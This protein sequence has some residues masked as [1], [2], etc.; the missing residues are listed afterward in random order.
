MRPDWSGCSKLILM[1]SKPLGK[2][3]ELISGE[4]SKAMPKRAQ[5]TD[6]PHPFQ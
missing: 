3:P 5:N 6:R 2:V 4:Y 1:N